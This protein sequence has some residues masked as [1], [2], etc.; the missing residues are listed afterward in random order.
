VAPAQRI[1]AVEFRSTDGRFWSAIGGELL[2]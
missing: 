2:E 1:L